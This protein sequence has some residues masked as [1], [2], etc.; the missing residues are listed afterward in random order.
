MKGKLIIVIGIVALWS[1][2]L[3][4]ENWVTRSIE[5]VFADSNLIDGGPQYGMTPRYGGCAAKLSST[6]AGEV[7]GCNQFITFACSG[8]FGNNKSI[9]NQNYQAAQ[10]AQAAGL[11]MRI[12]VIPERNINSFCFSP[13]AATC[14][15][16]TDCSN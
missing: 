5:R 3:V 8:V 12:Q 11:E 14:T 13:A 16:N 7:A 4:A 15:A 1:N 2:S 10:L 9:A 6:L